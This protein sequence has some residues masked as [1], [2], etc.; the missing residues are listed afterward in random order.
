MSPQELHFL[1]FCLFVFVFFY[2]PN[3]IFSWLGGPHFCLSVSVLSW[4]ALAF[5]F[6]N[7]SWTSCSAFC[8]C[9]KCHAA[10]SCV[11]FSCSASFIFWIL[12]RS[13]FSSWTQGKYN[14][15]LE[16]LFRIK[17]ENLVIKQSG[18]LPLSLS[19]EHI[20]SLLVVLMP[21]F[22]TLKKAFRGILTG[23]SV[24]SPFFFYYLKNIMNLI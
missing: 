18:K 3:F 5:W 19:P 10:N 20:C 13:S 11:V 8:C 12:S 9:L 22:W 16:A 1:L 17:Q 7:F 14:K 24:W 15:T 2:S 4:R 6:C 21:C 23:P